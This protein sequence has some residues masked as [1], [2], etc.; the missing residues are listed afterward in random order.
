MCQKTYKYKT[1]HRNPT[2]D[3]CMHPLRITSSSSK[4]KVTAS[5]HTVSIKDRDPDSVSGSVSLFLALTVASRQSWSL[6]TDSL[7]TARRV[8]PMCKV[9]KKK[10]LLELQ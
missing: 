1:K 4:S 10:S 5:V 6:L 2:A 7:T 3:G 9:K 8:S